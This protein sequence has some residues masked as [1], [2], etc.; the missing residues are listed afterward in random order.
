MLSTSARCFAAR[1]MPSC[2][3]GNGSRS[4]TTVGPVPSLRRI[5]THV[6]WPT[7]DPHTQ[8]APFA[9]RFYA[10]SG[11]S[12]PPGTERR[13]LRRRSVQVR[14][15]H[16]RYI[17]SVP[18]AHR[19]WPQRLCISPGRSRLCML[20]AGDSLQQND[21][22]F[23]PFL[24]FDTVRRSWR[25]AARFPSRWNP[26]ERFRDRLTGGARRA[27]TRD[28]VRRHGR[29]PA[30]RLDGHAVRNAPAPAPT[31]AA[32]LHDRCAQSSGA[33]RHTSRAAFERME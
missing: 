33:R 2:P 30:P 9:S 32:R 10:P 15:R 11:S 3:T 25:N 19:R 14:I 23:V 6:G 28:V 7:A 8:P 1:T 24:S 16:H 27:G 12:S 22:P 31:R 26:R 5:R 17:A 29:A 20:E 21:I 13:P 4:P 18:G